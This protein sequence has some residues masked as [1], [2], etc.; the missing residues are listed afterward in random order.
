MKVVIAKARE[1]GEKETEVEL[2]AV[3]MVKWGVKEILIQMVVQLVNFRKKKMKTWK[4]R[5][6]KI[7]KMILHLFWASMIIRLPSISEMW[8]RFSTFNGYLV[9]LP[10]FFLCPSVYSFSYGHYIGRISGNRNLEGLQRVMQVAPPG[11]L[12]EADMSIRCQNIEDSTFG[13]IKLYPVPEYWRFQF[14]MNKMN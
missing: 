2:V 6:I 13:W 10:F 14:W 11:S 9:S 4:V 3:Q 8:V 12:T 7:M 1:D 5:G